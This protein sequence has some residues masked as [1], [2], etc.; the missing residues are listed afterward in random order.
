MHITDSQFD[1]A[2]D[3]LCLSLDL[4]ELNNSIKDKVLMKVEAFRKFIV[5]PDPIGVRM[6]LFQD[7][8]E[9]TGIRKIVEQVFWLA[10]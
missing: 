9:E 2:M 3:G 4:M 1:A 7:L 5:N 10:S 6:S 8:G